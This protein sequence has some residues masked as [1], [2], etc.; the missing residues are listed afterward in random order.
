MKRITKIRIPATDSCN[1]FD[2][3]CCSFE[4]MGGYCGLFHT[5][6]IIHDTPEGHYHEKTKQC[7][8][9]FPNGTV[10]VEKKKK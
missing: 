7:L 1:Y 2:N 8:Q 6:L 5:N 3:Q 10:F 9:M 4:F